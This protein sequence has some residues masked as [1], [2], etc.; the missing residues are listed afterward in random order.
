MADTIP[1]AREQAFS[2]LRVLYSSADPL[3]LAETLDYYLDASRAPSS[4]AKGKGREGAGLGAKELIE[5]ISQKMSFK[6]FGQY[7]EVVRRAG[8]GSIGEMDAIRSAWNGARGSSG[9]RRGESS[10]GSGEINVALGKNLA[11]VRLHEMFPTTSIEVLKTQ[12]DGSRHSHLFEATERLLSL[13]SITPPPSLISSPFRIRLFGP[14]TPHLPE[15][16]LRPVLS[17]RNFYRSANYS[18]S[19]ILYATS[20]HPKIPLSVIKSLVADYPALEDLLPK[21]NDWEKT[22]HRI[23]KWFRSLLSSSTPNL[24]HRTALDQEL[25]DE[26]WSAEEPLRLAR[27]ALDEIFARKINLVEAERKGETFECECCYAVVTFEDLVCCASSMHSFCRE[28]LGGQIKECVYGSGVLQVARGASGEDGVGGEGSGVRC[29]S[30]EECG[31]SFSMDSLERAIDRTLFVGLEK[32]LAEIALESIT[33]GRRGLKKE[34]LVR[35][36]FCGY[37]E[38]M[39]DNSIFVKAFPILNPSISLFYL[40]LTLPYTLIS[41]VVVSLLYLL[42]FPLATALPEL[43]SSTKSDGEATLYPLLEPGRVFGLISGYLEGRGRLLRGGSHI[44]KCRNGPTTNQDLSLITSHTDLIRTLFPSSSSATTRSS[45]NCGKTSCTICERVHSVP[46]VCFG[47]EKEGLR[48]VVEMARSNAVK[49]L[50]P[51]CGVSFIKDGGCNRV[52]CQ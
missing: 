26:I 43:F 3:Y 27:V 12:L 22:Q 35:C 29:L 15:S 34:G 32:R 40:P 49:R 21:L 13:N 44:F 1:G 36:P 39:D 41:L 9:K 37:S 33:K 28:C 51:D 2:A 18:T 52:V 42:L 30:G 23:A 7:P 50:C 19:L 8:G 14:P 10:S 20:L 17:P 47:D 45:G 6:N 11:L 38:I 16:T 31:A 46:H 24:L 5:E 4:S 25:I 48:L